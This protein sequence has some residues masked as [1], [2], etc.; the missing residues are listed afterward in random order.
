MEY[1]FQYL[2]NLHRIHPTCRHHHTKHMSYIPVGP[3]VSG[4]CT[5]LEE[6]V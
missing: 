2:I 3:L 6:P 1:Q 5:S 4:I